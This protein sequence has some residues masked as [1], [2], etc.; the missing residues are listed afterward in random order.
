MAVGFALAL[1]TALLLMG[2]YVKGD[3]TL[4]GRLQTFLAYSSFTTQ[5]L[6]SISTVLMAITV[7]TEDVRAKT[8]FILAS[9]PVSRGQYVLGRWMGV[10]LLNVSALLLAMLT[11]YGL[12]QYI[13]SQP[14][15]IEEK[16]ALGAPKQLDVVRLGLENEVFTAR[17][18]H[19]PEPIDIDKVVE[20]RWTQIIEETGEDAL[21]QQA[22]RM[23][24]RSLQGIKQDEAIDEDRRREIEEEVV[25]RSADPD[26]R[27]D[28][29]GKLREKMRQTVTAERLLVKPGRTSAVLRFSGLQ[30]PSDPRQTLQFRYRL[31]PVKSP[32]SG[33]IKGQW[34]LSQS[35]GYRPRYRD[36]PAESGS[37]R[38]I[39]AWA[40]APDGTLTLFYLTHPDTPTDVNLKLNEI[41]LYY[42]VGSF[43]G[44]LLRAT[45]MVALRLLFLAALAVL[46]GL[47]LSFPVA[48]LTCAI[49][50]VIAL[51]GGFILKATDV[52]LAPGGPDALDYFSYYLVR[53]VFR[54]LPQLPIVDSPSEELVDGANIA[55]SRLLYELFLGTGVRAV[56]G[57]LL[58]WLIFRRRELARVQV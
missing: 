56:A 38:M 27:N 7:V 12:S 55:W 8:V 42:K 43:E 48:A 22:I 45:L 6:L 58:G 30:R 52:G 49:L 9:K 50:L 32:R 36:D 37:A 19:R 5:M 15:E 4:K 57:L 29:I 18:M 46:L 35:P 39:P 21:V 40:I 33:T 17:V 51:M 16:I 31:R 14:T 47:F 24:L 23:D 34:V 10:V 25:R 41:S 3:G 53:G 20:Q 26:V 1:W 13:R 2:L 28:I 44:N 11:I 54:I